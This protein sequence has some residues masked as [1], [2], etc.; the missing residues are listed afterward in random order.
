[1]S[2]REERDGGTD[3]RRV[4]SK[5]TYFR[6][7][8][9]DARAERLWAGLWAGEE[10]GRWLGPAGWAEFASRAEFQRNKRKSI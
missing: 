6:E 9:K 2:A 5:K 10:M 4:S 1:M 7:Y 8:A 3:G